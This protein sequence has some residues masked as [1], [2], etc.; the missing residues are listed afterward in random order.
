MSLRRRQQQLSLIRGAEPTV[1][2]WSLRLSRGD[3]PR[4]ES[5]RC[6]L[7]VL[8]EIE[9]GLVREVRRGWIGDSEVLL[10]VDEYAETMH[11]V[12]R[13]ALTQRAERTVLGISTPPCVH[14]CLPGS[15]RPDWRVR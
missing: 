13:P 7:R 5:L 2:Q 14:R 8:V 1:C 6:Y 11:T 3:S 15:T 9:V 10:L 12:P 4:S